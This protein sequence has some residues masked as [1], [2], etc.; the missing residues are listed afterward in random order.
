MIKPEN[1]T[2]EKKI[3]KENQN[4]FKFDKNIYN[5]IYGQEYFNLESKLNSM[6]ESFKSHLEKASKEYS[7]KFKKLTNSYY[8]YLSKATQKIQNAFELNS[9]FLGDGS[10][11]KN[12]LKLIQDYSRTYLEH[13]QNI[14]NFYEQILGNLQNNMNILLNFFDIT[15]ESFDSNPVE[16][17]LNQEMKNIINNWLFL[18]IGFDNYNLKEII[19]SEEMN[20]ELKKII[21]NACENKTFKIEFDYAKVNEEK[22]HE[23]SEDQSNNYLSNLKIK[24]F[25]NYFRSD[26]IIYPKLK[27]LNIENSYLKNNLNYKFP[28]LEKIII[29]LCHYFSLENLAY[30]PSNLKELN[31][32]SNDFIN[33][34]FNHIFSDYLTKN[35]NIRKKLEKISFKNNNISKIDFNQLVFSSKYTFYSLN[36][37]D[38]SKNRIYKFIIDPQ[39]FPALK[40]V[41]LCYNCLS[42]EYFNGLQDILILQSGNPFLTNNTLCISYYSNLKQKLN[43]NI[44]I[45]DSISLSY[46]PKKISNNFFSNLKLENKFLINLLS[47]D[48]SFNRLNTDSLFSFFGNNKSCLNIKQINLNGNELN[49]TFFEK[50]LDN[51]FYEIFDKLKILNMN[52]NLIGDESEINYKDEVPIKEDYKDY[53]KI[54]LKMRLIYKFLQLNKNLKLFSFTRN[55][56]GDYFLIKENN[57]KKM[58][59]RIVYDENNKIIINCFYTFLLKIRNELNDVCGHRKKELN[60]IFDCPLDINKNSIE[61]DYFENIIS[62][63][64]NRKILKN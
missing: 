43:D 4:N 6:N 19:N 11:D 62:F 45:I 28:N 9:D 50:Y 60:I 1:K 57:E 38:V 25:I 63:Q 29:N 24:N 47:L 37:I 26:N 18:K 27:T 59:K 14:I 40:V 51:K 17:F 20:D 15:T 3:Q 31:L 5:I 55:P 34:D 53:E 44:P 35:E 7:I 46:I 64:K 8:L 33:V 32:D 16:I 61:F 54:I 39:F 22:F 48:L 42:G 2:E 52:N 10:L 58:I 56:I 30:L 36:E 49:D 41:N 21:F 13:F 23:N 12:Q